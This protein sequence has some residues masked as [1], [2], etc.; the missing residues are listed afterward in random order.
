MTTEQAGELAIRSGDDVL[1]SGEQSG[2]GPAIVLLH[3]LTATRR[4]V[5]MGSRALERSGHRVVTYDARGHGRSSPSPSR[6]YTYPDLAEDLER[7]LDGAG[8]ER[9]V[10]AG[11]SMGAHTAV[12]FALAHPERVQALGVITPAFDPEHPIGERELADW[13]ALARGLREGGVEGFVAAYDLSGVP[14]EW[15]E[16]IET[17]LRQRLGAHEHPRAVADALEAVPRSRPFERIE[18]L[19]AI[20]VP[21]VVVGSR[22]EPDPGH[23][24]AAA[25]R[26]AAAIPGAKL[27]VE[28][29]SSPPRSP[30]A[31]Q[32]GQLSKLLGE[33]IAHLDT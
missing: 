18:E 24:L 21:T 28:E 22:D 5:V 4:Y 1:L 30:I 20:A 29:E 33:L 19:R 23:P 32:G 11:A 31:W 12:R 2:E 7:V 8:L 13:D 9:A 14:E 27:I 16:R 17:V 10:L 15:R 25:E 3:G 26:Y 6:S